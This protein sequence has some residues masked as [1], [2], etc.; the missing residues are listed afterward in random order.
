MTRSTPWTVLNSTPKLTQ[1]SE[2]VWQLWTGLTCHHQEAVQ[3]HP[4]HEEEGQALSLVCHFQPTR[5]I[6]HVEKR[7]SPW[8]SC[9]WGNTNFALDGTN[10]DF[11]WLLIQRGTWDLW[12]W[13]KNEEE[14]PTAGRWA[15]LQSCLCSL[16]PWALYFP[17][18]GLWTSEHRSLLFQNT[19]CVL[20]F[21]ILVLS[22]LPI[23]F[24]LVIAQGLRRSPMAGYFLI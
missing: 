19:A 22:L 23:K 2:R 13:Q 8:S 11:C 18:A 16:A 7:P 14:E 10:P 9:A 1:V 3:A 21:R 4:G 17:T 20:H 12:S 24:V 6:I 5:M 15:H